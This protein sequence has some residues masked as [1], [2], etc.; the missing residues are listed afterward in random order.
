MQKPSEARL[1][2]RPDMKAQAFA[3]ALQKEWLFLTSSSQG[4]SGKPS[5][6]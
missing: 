1:G 2:L 6:E 5:T 4:F 3:G